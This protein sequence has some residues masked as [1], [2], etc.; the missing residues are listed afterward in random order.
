MLSAAEIAFDDMDTW[1]LVHAS[2]SLG[3]PG[4]PNVDLEAFY[5]TAIERPY[6][7]RL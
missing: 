4:I 6:K 2:L 1:D 3:E 5:H 7:F